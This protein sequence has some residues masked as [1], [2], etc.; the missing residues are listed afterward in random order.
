MPRLPVDGKK[1]TEF[2]VTLGTYE[3]EQL[4]RFVDGMQVKNIGTGIGAAT[5]PIE[6]LFK[7]TAGTI[8]GVFFVAWALKRY[9]NVDVPIPTDLEDISEGWAAIL[10][11]I[12]NITDEARADIDK[13]IDETGIAD[14]LEILG[15]F[16]QFIPGVAQV[17]LATRI[18]KGAAN[19]I[20][21]P[22]DNPRYN[23]E[24]TD[25]DEDLIGGVPPT[26]DNPYGLTPAQRECV[27]GKWNQHL[28][29]IP[30]YKTKQQISIAIVYECGLTSATGRSVYLAL[31]NGET[32]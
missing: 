3:R 9:F 19:I 22:L 4:N 21:A 27:I 28:A 25:L 31:E 26:D 5:D 32:I 29:G 8:G 24:T 10:D 14:K 1:V 11:V 13:Y 18:L 2:R 12:T 6:A 30:Q 23:Y 17:G 20:F 7:T 16:A 15:P